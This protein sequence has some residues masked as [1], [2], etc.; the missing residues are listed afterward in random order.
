[1]NKFQQDKNPEGLSE[2]S[3]ISSDSQ[4]NMNDDSKKN[5]D[6]LLSAVEFSM[7]KAIGVKIDELNKDITEKLSRGSIIG[8]HVDTML[9]FKD[10][11][12]KFK[13]DYL[14][15]LLTT[16]YGNVSLVSK[17]TKVDRRSI[18]R[19]L[20]RSKKDLN[21]IREE[22]LKK[23][24][25]KK[26][27]ISFELSGILENYK[28]IIHPKRLEHAYSNMEETSEEIAK[29]IEEEPLTLK[30]AEDE[31]EKEYLTQVFKEYKGEVKELA[32]KIKLRYETLHRK[33]KKFGLI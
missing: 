18:H 10:A 24:Y 22:M 11:K 12:K 27:D 14:K 9:K 5:I 1:M 26:M 30:E 13:Q 21:K 3:N 32:K 4:D 15:K 20:S 17:L 33:L 19:L 7:Q 16:N 31:F 2:E 25:V 29:S 23:D 6:K 28:E 8:I